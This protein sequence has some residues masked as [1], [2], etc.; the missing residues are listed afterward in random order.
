LHSYLS[1][2]GVHS[3]LWISFGYGIGLIFSRM[4]PLLFGETVV[5]LSSAEMTIKY[6]FSPRRSKEIFPT[7]T[8]HS[9]HFVERSGE[10]PV[11]NK[12]GL[13]EIQFGQTHWTR[14]FGAGVTREEAEAIIAKMTEV[15][16]FPR[17]LPT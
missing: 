2:E 15:Y 16:P 6:K 14:Y 13:N 3:L 11:Q 4:T 8:L 10:V 9:F 17:Y 12:A 5:T 1:S 7:S